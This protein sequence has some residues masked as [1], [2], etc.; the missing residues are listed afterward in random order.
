MFP[1]P[2]PAVSPHA[3]FLGCVQSY[4]SRGDELSGE[5]EQVPF[6]VKGYQLLGWGSVDVVSNIHEFHGT[7]LHSCFDYH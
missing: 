3:P 5:W 2:K 6:L 1:K 7:I 4:V